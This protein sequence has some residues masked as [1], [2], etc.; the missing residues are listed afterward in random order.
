MSIDPAT[1]VRV[2][3]ACNL[4]GAFKDSIES[5]KAFTDTGKVD[6]RKF[7]SLMEK[8]AFMYGKDCTS[9]YFMLPLLLAKCGVSAD[10]FRWRSNTVE[11]VTSVLIGVG[12]DGEDVYETETKTVRIEAHP[13]AK[14][15][16][17]LCTEYLRGQYP[18]LNWETASSAPQVRRKDIPTDIL[19]TL[20]I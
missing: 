8:T 2:A 11:E 6:C 5:G 15:F 7:A 18:T 12:E 10:A 13:A 20:D 9:K 1:F 19:A 14:V 17:T 16:Q 4:S 3:I